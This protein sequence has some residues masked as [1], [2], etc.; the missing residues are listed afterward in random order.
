MKDKS[1]NPQSTVPSRPSGLPPKSPKSPA[2]SSP[3]TPILLFIILGSVADQA[4]RSSGFWYTTLYSSVITAIG[5]LNLADRL[6]KVYSEEDWFPVTYEDGVKSTAPYFVY[7]QFRV[8]LL[9]AHSP[10]SKST[11]RSFHS[12]LKGPKPT[13]SNVFKLLSLTSIMLRSLP[14]KQLGTS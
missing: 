4:F 7:S 12:C 3:R 14:R 2:S 13:P 1:S 8:I 11:P 10:I 6:G 5:D 9:C